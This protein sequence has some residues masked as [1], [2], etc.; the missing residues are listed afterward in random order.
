MN[1]VTMLDAATATSVSIDG[2]L[3][4][5]QVEV[6]KTGGLETKLDYYA[7]REAELLARVDEE[8]QNAARL[9][10]EAEAWRRLAGLRAFVR[11]RQADI[12]RT[13]NK[14]ARGKKQ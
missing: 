5:I 11:K 2:G 6:R 9:K 4:T 13:L 1:S 12:D 10:A 7:R 14:L 3:A 8:P